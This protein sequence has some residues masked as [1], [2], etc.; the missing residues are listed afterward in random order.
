MKRLIA[1]ALCL[2]FLFLGACKQKGNIDVSSNETSSQRPTMSEYL[3][4]F[5]TSGFSNSYSLAQAQAAIQKYRDARMAYAGGPSDF[6]V[7][8]GFD[9]EAV[10]T[11]TREVSKDGNIFYVT[12]I[13]YFELLMAIQEYM[14]HAWFQKEQVW[15][16]S[17]DLKEGGDACFKMDKYEKLLVLD[18]H[19]IVKGE[20][21]VN[22]IRKGEDNFYISQ[23]TVTYTDGTVKQITAKVGLTKAGENVVV[24]YWEEIDSSSLNGPVDLPAPL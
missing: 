11:E 14:T 10:E 20:S 22:S 21:V 17:L 16:G 3:S 6:L 5:D 18:A 8:L 7:E 15:L 4:D 2:A 9:R 12:E 13:N 23:E 19:S 24:G 1:L